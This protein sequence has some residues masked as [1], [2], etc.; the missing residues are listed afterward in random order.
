MIGSVTTTGTVLDRILA[1]TVAD[2]ATRKSAIPFLSLERRAAAR[3]APIGLATALRGPDVGVIAEIKRASPSRGEFPV[4]VE[5]AIVA[6][7]YLAGG[8]AALS[9]LTD[10][11]FFRGSLAD[12][13]AAAEVAHRQ[14]VPVLRKDCMVDT[15][16]M[17][18]ALA[19][20]ADVILLIV[21]ALDQPLL[22]SL[23][24]QAKDLGLSALVEVHTEE[25]MRR[26]DAAG[27]S[28]IGINNRDL[29]T[30]KVDLAV[31]ERLAP[32]APSDALLIGESGIFSHADV[33]RLRRAGVRAVL[34][35]ESLI[36]APDRT[37]AVRA[38]RG[39]DDS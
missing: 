5:P 26:A 18:E 38:L 12:L 3:N 28:I 24:R 29:K 1:Q 11:P 36:V 8:A 10:G 15:S 31:T 32:L 30:F 23:L 16:Q 6:N 14:G 21:A 22:E 27:A 19:Y 20:G 33:E 4:A 17:V 13:E 7:E 39:A 25:E 2:V 9:V 34:V 37:A 35:G